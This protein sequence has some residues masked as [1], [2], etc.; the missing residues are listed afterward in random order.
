MKKYEV[1]IKEVNYGY[2]I[3]DADDPKKATEIAVRKYHH[4]LAVMDDDPNIETKTIREI[5]PI[6]FH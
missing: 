5:F 2:I 4:G 6:G 3:V 1:K